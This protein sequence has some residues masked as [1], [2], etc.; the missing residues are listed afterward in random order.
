MP[1]QGLPKILLSVLIIVLL[2][3]SILVLTGAREATGDRTNLTQDTSKPPQTDS[4]LERV[5]DRR[6]TG[7]EDSLTQIRR[8][9]DSL[10]ER[11]SELESRSGNG[12]A[13][14][15]SAEELIGPE[16]TLRE[17]LARRQGPPPHDVPLLFD[18][19]ERGIPNAL[20]P[21]G[22][23]D[24]LAS[25]ELNPNQAA[26]DSE[27]RLRLAE[28]LASYDQK[29]LAAKADILQKEREI[30]EDR[31]GAYDDFVP[32]RGRLPTGTVRGESRTVVDGKAVFFRIDDEG[33]YQYYATEDSNPEYFEM[34]SAFPRLAHERQQAVA[35]FIAALDRE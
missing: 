27:D 19:T 11:V 13:S 8:S 23:Q 3:T 33:S 22:I 24:V 2:V 7:I 12:S 25:D 31:F 15:V 30:V 20:P 26:L 4:R 18:G 5:L 16:E 28:L 10:G 1:S 6:M 14:N 35:D 17:R 21:L 9:L 34:Y 29:E 32:F